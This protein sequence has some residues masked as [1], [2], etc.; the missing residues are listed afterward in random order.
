[1]FYSLNVLKTLRFS[2]RL[3]ISTSNAST[4]LGYHREWCSHVSSRLMCAFQS[5]HNFFLE[6]DA[7]RS[8]TANLSL[9]RSSLHNEYTAEFVK[10]IIWSL[11]GC[12]ATEA[13]LIA[14]PFS[15]WVAG[16]ITG[17]ASIFFWTN[18]FRSIYYLRSIVLDLELER[19]NDIHIIFG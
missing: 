15:L 13:D 8:N 17:K 18:F 11:M 9:F 3:S 5:P 7:L 10:W 2:A 6:R 4:T 1:M 14:I 19:W 16:G 12:H